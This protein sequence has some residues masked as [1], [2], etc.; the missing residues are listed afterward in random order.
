VKS[1]GIHPIGMEPNKKK[2]EKEKKKLEEKEMNLL[3]KPVIVQKISA[4]TDP[5]SVVCAFFKQG[6]CNENIDSNFNLIIHQFSGQCTK[7]AKCKFSHDLAVE[8]RSEKKS[9]YSDVREADKDETMEG[10]DENKLKEVVEKK[11]AAEKKNATTIICK[12]FLEAV[13]KSLY[14]W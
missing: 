5:K 11:H 6:L 8:R 3:F 4:D 7:G 9:I 12:Y 10:W 1:G 2:E 14:G 13:E